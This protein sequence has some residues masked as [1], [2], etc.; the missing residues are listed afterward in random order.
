MKSHYRLAFDIG[1]TFTDFVLHDQNTNKISI[2]K[3]L[4][5]PDDPSRGAMQGLV[6]LLEE[7]GLSLENVSQVVHG[8]T[9]VTNT[10]IERTGSSVG[11]LTTK[12]FRDILEMGTEQRYDIHDLFLDFPQPLVPRKFCIEV[13]ERIN[14]DGEIE[15]KIKLDQVLNQ[16]DLLVSE[17]VDS[18]AIS[19]L[20]SYCNPAHEILARNAIVS[21]LPK[22]EVSISSEINPQLREYERASTTIVNAYVKPLMAQYVGNLQKLM[23]QQGFKGSFLFMQSSGGLNSPETAIEL[24]VRFVESGPAGGGQASAW[25]GGQIGK[26]D[27]MSFDMGGTTAKSCLIRNGT[28]DLTSFLEAGRVHRFKKGSGMP[29]RAATI[30][31]IEIGA[32]GGSI[33]RSDEMDL[34]KVG[35]KSSGADPGPVCYSR[36]GQD[37]TV[38][39]A[40][41]LLGYLNPQYFLGGKIT[42]N[43][44]KARESYDQLGRELSISWLEAAW[45]AFELVCENMASAARVHIVEKGCDPRNYAMVSMGGAGPAHAARVARKLGISE[46]VVPQ[47]SGAASAFGLLVAPVSFSVSHSAPVVLSELDFNSINVLLRELEGECISKL[48]DSGVSKDEIVLQRFAE[49]RLVGQMHEITIALPAEDLNEN[50]LPEIE[51]TFSREY[52]RLYTHLYEGARIQTLNWMVIGRSG[53]PLISSHFFPGKSSNISKKR[54]RKAFF[55]EHGGMIE[56]SVY[57]RYSLSPG[58][59]IRGPAIVEEA[60]STTI[61]PPDSK[62]LV[63]E[64]GNLVIYLGEVKKGNSHISE[65]QDIAEVV[66]KLESDPVG[67]EIMWSRLINI[68]EECWQTVIRTAFSLIIGECQDFACELLDAR[69]NQLVHSPRAM[70]VFNICLPVAVKSMLERHPPETLESGDVLVTNDPWLCA[71]H[72]YDVAFAAPVYRDKRLVAFVG[73]VGHVSDIGGTRNDLGAREIYDEGLQIPPMKL[74]KAGKPNQ[75]LLDLVYE[76]VRNPSQVL[77]DIHAL[78]SAART[79]AVRLLEF[80]DEYGVEDLESMAQVVQSRANLAMRRA[81]GKLPDGVYRNEIWSDGIKEPLRFPVKVEVCGE[82]IKVDFSGAPD[83]LTFGGSNATFNYTLAHSTYP[84]KCI[85]TPEVPSN[86]GCYEPMFVEAPSMSILNCDKPMSVNARVRTGWYV[87]PNIYGALAKAIPEK[88]QAFTGLPSSAYFYGKDAL[89]V[90]ND[91]LFQGGGQGASSNRDG[92]SALLWPTSAANTSVEM[93][94][95]RVPLLVLEKSLI[96]DSGGPGRFRGGLGQII[97][98]R[99]LKDDG[100]NVEGGLFPIGVLNPPAGLLGGCSGAPAGATIQ[101]NAHPKEDLGIGALVDLS[102]IDDIV[103]LRI[104]GGAGFGNPLQRNL[105]LIE[106]D[107]QQGYIS[108]ERAVSKYGCSVD[109][110]GKIDKDKSLRNRETIG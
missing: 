93:L 49:M 14:R 30:D 59:E 72:L 101:R 15:E 11:L 66:K 82:E 80:M 1:G 46:V 56:S 83:Q 3:C 74:F 55:P 20:H 53:I 108:I 87:G 21:K 36:G 99:K 29:I 91:H 45:G 17:G 6:E 110:T 105:D 48:V 44:E 7:E 68:T 38:T 61:V 96:Q 89:G 9:L 70:P 67:L 33:A 64:F 41:L 63:D 39:D 10:L 32:G 18:L 54:S 4:T 71:G 102:S 2:N 94:E 69:G 104:A 65:S 62:L 57:D 42:L 109:S 85:L 90:F 34:M 43:Y 77:G 52:T 76:N 35:P 98:V 19:F 92:K 37:P 25:V 27:I 26:P 13:D 100:T 28:P 88:V 78:V 79:G 16:V 23:K 86:A 22:L 107:L 5:T 73:I 12:G 106:E 40:N 51:E 103:E 81:I 31:M 75:D 50:S 84:L 58:V 24:P 95:T 60:E 97:R 8:T 47:A